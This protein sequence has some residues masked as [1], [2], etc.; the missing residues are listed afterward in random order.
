MRKVL[1]IMKKE[2]QRFFTDRRMLL[3]LILPGIIL[4]CAYSL[5]GNFIGDMLVGEEDRKYKIAINENTTI[6][7]AVLDEFGLDYE[8]IDGYSQE[9]ALNKLKNEEIDLYVFTESQKAVENGATLPSVEVYYNSTSTNSTT[10]Y[11]AFFTLLSQS[12]MEVT[13]IFYVNA[14]KPSYDIA[15]DEDMTAMIL[16]MMFPLIM[17]VFLF[18]GCMAVA[19]ESIAGE[20]ERGTIATLLITP[21]KRSYIALGKVLALSITS[22]ASAVVSFLAVM[23]SLPKLMSGSVGGEINFDLSMY[24][25]TE[26][27]GLLVVIIFTVMLFTVILSIVSTLAKSVKEATSYASPVMILIMI[28][29]LLGSFVGISGNP[30]VC[31]IPIYNAVVCMSSILALSLNPLYIVFTII[32]NSVFIGLGIVVLAKLFSS[33]RIMF[34]K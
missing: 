13:P 24:G 10:V 11:T 12:S 33:E 3:T 29:T 22:L 16:T 15:S 8:L 4:Y 9:T 23:L 26:I 28:I 32:S 21:V 17:M 5:M 18:S 20:K 27:L 25:A 1:T 30:I 14:F 31:L 2:L 6:T 7:Q 34:N 19:T